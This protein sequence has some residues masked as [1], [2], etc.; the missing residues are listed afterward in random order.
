[1]SIDQAS[2]S[3][4]QRS[5]L[6]IGGCLLF[7]IASAS[8]GIVLLVNRHAEYKMAGFEIVIVGPSAMLFYLAGMG[9]GLAG[10]RRRRENPL[11][12]AACVLNGIPLAYVV[13]ML[14]F[15]AIR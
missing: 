2:H 7:A 8:L 5:Y 14:L 3:V 10:M 15:A 13:L 6:G 12:L 1:M 11:S 9:M 4:P